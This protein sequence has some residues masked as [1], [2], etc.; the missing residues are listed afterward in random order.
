[1]YPQWWAVLLLTVV[2]VEREGVLKETI[3]LLT[4][5]KDRFTRRKPS[6]G[7]EIRT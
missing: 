1:M 6:L 7:I 5:V 3:R 2:N 4:H